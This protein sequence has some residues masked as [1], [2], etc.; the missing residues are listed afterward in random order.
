ME[1][2][3]KKENNFEFLYLKGVPVYFAKV[4][5]P[6]F[7]YQST[8]HKEYSLNVFLSKKVTEALE[9]TILVNKELKEVGVGL[10]KKRK[11]KYPLDTFPGM[12]GLFGMNL[13]SPEFSGSGASSAIAVIK[14][15]KIFKENIGNGSICDIKCL[16]WRNPDDLLN[17]RLQI[18]VVKDHI[19]YESEVSLNIVDNELGVSVEV[20]T[21]V[22][23]SEDIPEASGDV[24][25]DKIF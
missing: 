1:V 22:E 18:V 6:V 7:K 11:I 16:G 13:S 4:H 8:E 23:A 10:N 5:S 19:P 25:I 15:N 2:K 12:D 20:S 24:D 9:N 3:I 14:D 17:L 21:V